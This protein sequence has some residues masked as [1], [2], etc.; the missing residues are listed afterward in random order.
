MLASGLRVP[1][2]GAH[3]LPS[4]PLVG[5]ALNK[6]NAGIPLPLFRMERLAVWGDYDGTGGEGEEW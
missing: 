3:S 6:G 5:V 4:S 1:S 2:S